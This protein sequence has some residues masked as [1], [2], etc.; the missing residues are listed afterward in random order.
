MAAHGGLVFFLLLLTAR[1]FALPLDAIATALG[2]LRDYYA[3][4]VFVTKQALFNSKDGSSWDPLGRSWSALVTQRFVLSRSHAQYWLRQ[5]RPDKSM[6][7][8]VSDTGV[9]FAP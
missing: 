9:L 4:T 5:L 3:L 6:R 1:F 2:R 8:T 7:F